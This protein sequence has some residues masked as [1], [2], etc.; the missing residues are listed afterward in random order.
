[1]ARRF[2]PRGGQECVDDG[3]RLG[4]RVHPAADADQLGVVVLTGQFRG[5]DAPGQR[6]PGAGD[7][8]GRDLLAVARPAQHDA[9]APRVGHRALRGG[10]AERR[11]VVLG[12]IVESAA[13]DRLVAALAKVLDDGLLEFV[14]GVIAAEVDAHG[15]NLT[16]A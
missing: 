15:R 7:L 10:D 5:L 12:V 11:V 8:V 1:V 16:G 9:Q 13:I 6:A 3:Q 2:R 4:L 14:A